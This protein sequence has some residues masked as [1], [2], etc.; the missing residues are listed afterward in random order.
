M[1]DDVV[2]GKWTEFKGEIQSQWAKLTSD[3]LEQT[4][5]NLKSIVGIIEQKYGHAKD[6]VMAKLNEMSGRL[7]Q[8]ATDKTNAAT[9]KAA[10]MTENQK[11]KLR[12]NK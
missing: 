4:K 8:G 2:K 3:D 10:S 7:S 9:A 11:N 5:G 1:N 12:Q 6:D